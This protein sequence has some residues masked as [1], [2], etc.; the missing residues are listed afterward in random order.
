VAAIAELG[1][2]RGTT[3][4]NNIN[5]KI[6]EEVGANYR[7]FLGWR[8]AAF[9]GYLIVVGTAVSFTMSTL[10]DS[11]NLAFIIPIGAS[12]IGCLLW[13][14]DKRN[15]SIYA[16]ISKAGADLE[17]K[18]PGS[19]KSLSAV[20]FPKELS[21]LRLAFKR[22]W[23]HSFSLDVL[24]LGGSGALLL[25]AV[26]LYFRVGA[27]PAQGQPTSIGITAGQ[28]C[29]VHLR[30]DALALTVGASNV[31]DRADA[32]VAGTLIAA[33]S[34]GVQLQQSTNGVVWIPVSSI[35]FIEP[36]P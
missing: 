5:E 13:F 29:R 12:P 4:M 28:A 21:T 34:H 30:R 36:K 18:S 32:L 2:L 9:A 33:D 22:N 23:S 19:Y 25:L 3:R 27:A 7:F 17:E 15:R 14:I 11:P 16:A 35:L 10:K 24:F 26:F 8:H 1:S 20:A 6:Y 31:L